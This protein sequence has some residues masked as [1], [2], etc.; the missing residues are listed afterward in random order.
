MDYAAQQRSIS[1]PIR[2]SPSP[3]I[4]SSQNQGSY[5]QPH[6]WPQQP[7][8][9]TSLTPTKNPQNYPARST[10][11]ELPRGDNGVRNPSTNLPPNGSPPYQTYGEPR[12]TPQ[13]SNP[14]P[15]VH[16]Y[17]P[18]PKPTFGDSNSRPFHKAPP[19]RYD[20]PPPPTPPPKDNNNNNSAQRTRSNVLPN[21]RT[22]PKAPDNDPFNG[23]EPNQVPG[24]T[25]RSLPPLKTSLPPASLAATKPIT[26]EEIR[27][28]RQKQ[29]EESNAST[30]KSAAPKGHTPRKLSDD[31]KIVMSSTSYPGQEWQPSWGSWED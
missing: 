24:Q 28:L 27:K 15:P 10:S 21:V 5:Q 2:P 1:N 4:L 7:S 20:S 25:R 19:S 14:P 11:R 22:A 12:A 17:S 3:A 26:P 16:G 29:I 8:N 13:Q 30:P 31:E 6:Y 23:P 18:F 9:P